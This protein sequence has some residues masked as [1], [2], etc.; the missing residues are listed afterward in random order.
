MYTFLFNDEII[1]GEDEPLLYPIF[2]VSSD[3]SLIRILI[4]K[5]MNNNKVDYEIGNQNRYGIYIETKDYVKINHNNVYILF[6]DIDALEEDKDE[7]M[8]WIDQMWNS[9]KNCHHI[10]VKKT[11][12]NINFITAQECYSN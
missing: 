1:Y 11:N 2:I 4:G 12:E 8:I 6:H 7:M 9:N 10:H 5:P 3:K